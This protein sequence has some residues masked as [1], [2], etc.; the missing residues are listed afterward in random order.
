MKPLINKI[1][2]VL[3]D[4]YFLCLKLFLLTNWENFAK[5]WRILL[6]LKILHIKILI[7]SKLREIFLIGLLWAI[8]LN[9]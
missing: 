3:I 7:F 5:F 9:D 8:L 2:K 4:Y 1:M 6:L